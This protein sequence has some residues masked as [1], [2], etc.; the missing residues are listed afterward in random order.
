MSAHLTICIK[1]SSSLLIMILENDNWYLQ[2]LIPST[3]A[4]HDAR[5]RLGFLLKF[6]DLTRLGV[7]SPFL[8]AAQT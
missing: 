1:S 7:H 5:M 6:I 4:Q 3:P 8:L 2:T